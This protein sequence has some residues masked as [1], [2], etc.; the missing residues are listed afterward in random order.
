MLISSHYYCFFCCC[1]GYFQTRNDPSEIYP[2]F[3]SSYFQKISNKIDFR[4]LQNPFYDNLSHILTFS[5]LRNADIYS[6]PLLLKS[7]SQLSY[8]QFRSVLRVLGF[9][10]ENASS[11]PYSLIYDT[12]LKTNS[13]SLFFFEDF[14][15]NL[16]LFSSL[17]VKRKIHQFYQILQIFDPSLSPEG[18]LSSNKVKEFCHFLNKTF[19]LGLN[20]GEIVGIVER[21]VEGRENRVLSV[22]LES[23]NEEDANPKN[24]TKVSKGKS[25]KKKESVGRRE[26]MEGRGRREG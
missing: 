1:L 9:S 18:K 3:H 19:C 14:L 26:E 15:V 21:E 16:V 10:Q 25:I 22:K 13:R 24:K 4:L 23:V 12:L 20:R 11:M 5:R 6:E 17:T 2:L 7:G 8:E